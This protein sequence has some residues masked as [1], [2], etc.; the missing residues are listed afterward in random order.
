VVV[1]Q[2]EA[3]ESDDLAILGTFAHQAAVALAKARVRDAAGRRAS[4]LYLVSAAAEIATSTLDVSALLGSI[5]RYV[6][7]SFEYPGVGVYLVDAAAREVA[8]EGASGGAGMPSRLR[9][10]DGVVGWAAEHGERALV[11]D[12]RR[13]PRFQPAGAR[14][15]LSALAVPVRL[16]GEVVAVIAAESEQADAFDFNDVIA[17]D[18]IA[19]QVAAGIRNARLFEEKV[20][21]LRSLEILQEIT[22]VLNSDLELDAL[23][24]RIARRSVEAVKPAQMGSVL[25]YDGDALTVRSSFGYPRPE[26]L[27][28][29]RLAFHEGL[30]GSVFVSG[31]G[32]CVQSS[33]S[34]RG[35]AAGAFRDATG[36]ERSKG[37]L[38]VPISLPQQKL[39]VLLL[40][41]FSSE[42]FSDEDLR[43]AATLADQAAIAIG[44][45]LHLRKILELDRQRQNYLSNVSHE[46]RTPLTVIQGYVEA[47]RS[48]ISGDPK[49]FLR[50]VE[51][52]CQR[53]GRMIEEVLEVSRLEQG[54]AQRHVEWGPVALPA[55]VRKVVRGLRQEILLKELRLRERVE[56]G[57]PPL[58]GDERLLQLL[59]S[60]VLEN[61]VKFTPKG[62]GV[63]VGLRAEDGSLVLTVRDDGIGIPEEHWERI[64]DKFF[65]VSDGASRTHGGAGIGLYLA[66]EVAAIHDGRIRVE[67]VEGRGSL[68]EVR[69]P[70]RPSR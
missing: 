22:N 3:T 55:I 65:T 30:P 25:L 27:A 42:A 12:V 41:S 54:V 35:S 64:F 34:D 37:A 66:R 8:L 39:G 48:G 70:V 1:R 21:A 19:A 47:L 61:A 57:L 36:E 15:A 26:A 29:V 69:L 4:Q 7:R 53:L 56:D 46:L 23:L 20:R 52:Q 24:L 38:C 44:N 63:E 33:A 2:D 51:E 28:R 18:A 31:H 49:H 5:A 13:E 17:L 43:F 60:N 11:R 6:Q 16:A 68:F 59:V 9:F 58:P 67:S 10:G 62:G 14:H 40:E 45:A 32:R 50:I